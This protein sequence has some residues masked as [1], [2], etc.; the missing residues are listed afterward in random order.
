MKQRE[1]KKVVVGMKASTIKRKDLKILP[2]RGWAEHTTYRKILL[3]PTGTKHD[4][5]FMHIAIVGVR[6]DGGLEVCAYPDDIIWDFST[7]H[8]EYESTGMRTDC[9][10]PTGVLQFWG[11]S[12][13][14]IVKGA[15]SSTIIQVVNRKE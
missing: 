2:Q 3:V 15:F 14:F 12:T 5:G 1:I 11:N 9:F 6:D 4:S 10:Y 7:F 8:Q 13:A